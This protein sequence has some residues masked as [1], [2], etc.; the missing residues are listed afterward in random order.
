MKAIGRIVQELAPG[1]LAARKQEVPHMME[2]LGARDFG[3]LEI[4]GHSLKGSGGSFGFPELTRFGASLERY[5]KQADSVCFSEE[6]ARLK[7]YL[8]DLEVP[9]DTTTEA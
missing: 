8:R 9:A 4:L 7:E 5:A 3:R 2:L 1:Y 6:L